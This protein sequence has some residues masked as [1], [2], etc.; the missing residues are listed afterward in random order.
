MEGEVVHLVPYLDCWVGYGHGTAESGMARRS[1]M[2]RRRSDITPPRMPSD[3][4]LHVVGALYS[5]EHLCYGPFAAASCDVPS[6]GSPFS[7]GPCVLQFVFGKLWR[8][9]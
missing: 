9:M 4:K 7:N 8:S 1:D 2:A 5:I 6:R 3:S